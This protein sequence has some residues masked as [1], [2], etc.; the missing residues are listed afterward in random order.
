[1]FLPI[2][3]SAFVAGPGEEDVVGTVVGFSDSSSRV[4]AFAVV[5]VYLKRT[6]VVPVDK[7][8]KP[9]PAEN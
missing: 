5:D 6:V 4:R 2:P 1:V 3:E 9:G 8:R 7:L